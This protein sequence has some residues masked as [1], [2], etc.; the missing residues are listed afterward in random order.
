MERLIAV[1]LLN[2]AAFAADT[3]HVT[4][5]HEATRDNEKTYHTVFSQNIITGVVGNRRYTLEQLMSWGYFHFRVGA[6]YEV[7][8]ADD[9]G[10]TVKVQ[11]KKGRVF[12]ERLNLVT[13]E[14]VQ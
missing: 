14:E 6:D 8:K 3:L 4:T 9:K 13:V 7:V 11:D 12:K 5:I 2:T 1:L 10:I